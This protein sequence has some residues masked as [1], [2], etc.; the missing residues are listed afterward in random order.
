MK[1]GQWML[2]G[3]D[4]ERWGAFE[5]FDTK[6]EAIIYGVELLTEYNSLDDD[7][8]RDYDLSDGLNM[9]PLD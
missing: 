8:R 6:E 2:N 7:E 9:R 5:R 3:T 1:H 4:G